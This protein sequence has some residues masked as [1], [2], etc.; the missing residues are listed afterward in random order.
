MGV[1]VAQSSGASAA[2]VFV[3]AGGQ[4]FVGGWDTGTDPRN[5]GLL[6][7]ETLPVMANPS[8]A[9]ATV[10]LQND[11]VTPGRIALQAADISFFDG[12]TPA[13]G[14]WPI[15]FFDGF[16]N[17]T[18]A[19]R[20]GTY[21]T[22]TLAPGAHRDL[23]LSVKNVSNPAFPAAFVYLTTSGQGQSMVTAAVATDAV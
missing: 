7:F 13:D 9:N 22:P 10:R 14:S 19:V 18:A 2:D 15:A 21:T 20:A 23:R 11:S 4:P 17:V 3:K 1:T 12:V 8:T 6:P 5:N 16:K